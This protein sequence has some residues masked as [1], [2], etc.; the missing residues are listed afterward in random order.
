MAY[1]TQGLF[2]ILILCLLKTGCSF[3]AQVPIPGPQLTDR[4]CLGHSRV[5]QRERGWG[6]STRAFKA[7]AQKWLMLFS[8]I[9]KA[10]MD[11][12]SV[13][14]ILILPLRAADRA[15]NICTMKQTNRLLK[16]YFPPHSHISGIPV[17]CSYWHFVSAPCFYDISFAFP[18][19]RIPLPLFIWWLSSPLS[20]TS[21]ERS[22]LILSRRENTLSCPSHSPWYKILSYCVVTVV[23]LFPSRDYELLE[24]KVYVLFISN[25]RT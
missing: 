12:V 1:N 7:S 22:P 4:P 5:W 15:T 3:A 20:I 18:L 2:S 6:E 19:P 11:L 9:S 10:N 25:P 13:E 14:R 24:E 16:P 8:L 23:D 17:P 21:L